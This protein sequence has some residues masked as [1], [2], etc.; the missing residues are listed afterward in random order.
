MLSC[1]LGLV[2]VFLFVLTIVIGIVNYNSRYS[3]TPDKEPF[4]FLNQ[5]PYELQDNETM[6]YNLIFRIIVALMAGSYILFGINEFFF[7]NLHEIKLAHDYILGI[8]FIIIGLSMFFSFVLNLKRYNEHLIVSSILF[9][10][11]VVLCAYLGFFILIDE[12]ELYSPI[13]AYIMFVI[14]ALLLAT[15]I[16]SPL[17]RWMYLEKEEKDGR[18]TYHRK[19]I[20]ILPLI[21]WI[22]LVVNVL[23]VILITFF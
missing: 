20:S 1:I 12:R 13:L 3:D 18:V 10:L 16:I 15:L 4:S 22:F 2:F 9:G 19:H 8:I 21:E 17:K 23:I 14:A 6:K 5:F 7:V 11:T